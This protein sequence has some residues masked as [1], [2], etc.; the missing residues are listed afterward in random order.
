MV[1]TGVRHH[2]GQANVHGIRFLR[3]SEDWVAPV[4]AWREHSVQHRAVVLSMLHDMLI[5]QV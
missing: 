5:W 2:L 1:R 3:R 4:A